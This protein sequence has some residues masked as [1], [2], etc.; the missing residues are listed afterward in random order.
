[1]DIERNFQMAEDAA[2]SL[3]YDRDKWVIRFARPVDRPDAIWFCVDTKY[4]NEKTGLYRMNNRLVGPE[5]FD[6]AVNLKC[7]MQ[8]WLEKLIEE[9]EALPP[10]TIEEAERMR[11]M[12]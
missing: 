9:I 2:K 6:S 11:A 8:E 1:M 7:K 4:P 10:P 12:A 5:D 3:A